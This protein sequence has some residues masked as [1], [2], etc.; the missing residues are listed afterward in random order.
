MDFDAGMDFRWR[1]GQLEFC[2]LHELEEDIGFDWIVVMTHITRSCLRN[3]VRAMTLK[4]VRSFYL[5]SFAFVV[6]VL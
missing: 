2:L 6:S 3:G 5:S 1:I 4:Y